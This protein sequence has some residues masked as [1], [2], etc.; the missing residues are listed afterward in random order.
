MDDKYPVPRPY[1]ISDSA[2]WYNRADNCLSVWRDTADPE[3][4]NDVEIH[5]QKIRNK[6][7]GTVGM[8]TLTWNYV[9]GTFTDKGGIA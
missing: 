8:A 9:C 5:V 1:D 6:Y 2:H 3:K 4:R 7:V